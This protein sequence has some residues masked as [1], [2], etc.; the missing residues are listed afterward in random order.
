MSIAVSVT[1]VPS[2]MLRI[3]SG[4]LC[5]SILSAAGTIAFGYIGELS[6]VFRITL[7]LAMV[8]AALLGFYHTARQQ[9]ALHIDITGSGQFRIAEIS[10]ADASCMDASWPQVIKMSRPCRLLE[11][12]TLWPCLLL[13][14]LQE[15]EGKTRTIRILPDSLEGDSFRSLAAACRWMAARGG[16]TDT[17][18]VQGSK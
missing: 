16:D 15:P 3:L 13:L 10:S 8:F 4:M 11:S 18:P 7:A 5:L 2:R 12:S 1:V 14:R 17:R 9:K 6:P